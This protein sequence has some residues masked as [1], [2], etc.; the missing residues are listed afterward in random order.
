MKYPIDQTAIQT[1]SQSVRGELT[2]KMAV[3]LV[4]KFIGLPC[5]LGNTGVD[6]SVCPHRVNL[7]AFYISSASSQRLTYTG[8][9]DNDVEKFLKKQKVFL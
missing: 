9:S 1:L 6:A 3:D 5:I 8:N 2:E 4:S 7:N